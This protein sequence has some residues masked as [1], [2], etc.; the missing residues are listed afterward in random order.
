MEI[1][2][3]GVESQSSSDVEVIDA[4][5]ESQAPSDMEIINVDE[6][7]SSDVE[8]L[9]QPGSDA[10]VPPCNALAGAIGDRTVAEPEEDSDLAR[11]EMDIAPPP[12][13]DSAV[14]Q[15]T[16]DLAAFCIDELERSLMLPVRNEDHGS[17]GTEDFERELQVRFISQMIDKIPISDPFR[18]PRSQRGPVLQMLLR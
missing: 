13:I 5:E 11:S 16:A 6:V 10:V 3:A 15:L 7:S 4:G 8:I 18:S 9:S 2:D 12:F 1:L 14:D 17:G